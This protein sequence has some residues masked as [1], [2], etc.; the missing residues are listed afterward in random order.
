MTQH[1]NV[2]KR[3]RRGISGLMQVAMIVGIVVIF[4]GA[5]FV[6]A[7]DIFTVH[8]TNNT[9]AMQRVHIYDVG[10][11]AYV[12]ANIKNMGNQDVEQVTL[13]ILMDADPGTAEL[14]SF[15]L[16]LS[17]SLLKPGMSGSAQSKLAYA[18][19]TAVSLAS[20]TEVAA[21]LEGMSVDGSTISEPAI[22]RVR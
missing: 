22:I 10:G 1:Y 18:N 21:V 2:A 9:L 8:T 15:D 7:N 17:P 19:G 3:R 5:L 20:G 12:S 11:E 4:A 6:F 13:R 16:A 14:D